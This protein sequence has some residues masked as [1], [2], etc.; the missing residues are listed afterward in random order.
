MSH[1]DLPSLTDLRA[2]LIEHEAPAEALRIVDTSSNA[3]E[4]LELL[5]EA[6]LL[7][8][9]GHPVA[10]LV[11]SFAPL[12]EPGCGPLAAELSG[13]EFLGLLRDGIAEEDL[14]DALASMIGDAE[15]F[16]SR[17]ALAMLRVF[18][19][20]APPEV[21]P[22]AAEAADRLVASGLKDPT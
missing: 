13:S 7:P 2:A 6:G 10:A 21:R 5:A 20:L 15:A 16:G 17:E 12:L 11:E 1:A 19:V 8:F 4:A 18:A 9:S 22:M 14:V 3:V